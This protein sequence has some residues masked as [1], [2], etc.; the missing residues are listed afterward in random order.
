[1]L[2]L[3]LEVYH[4]MVAIFFVSAV[5]LLFHSMNQDSVNQIKPT[6]LFFEEGEGLF[7]HK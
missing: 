4:Y 3:L 6:Y 2:I 1:M 5:D 7:G